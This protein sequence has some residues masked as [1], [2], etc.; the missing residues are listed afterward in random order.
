LRTA[1]LRSISRAA[2]SLGIAQPSLS[3]QLLRLEDEVGFQLFIRTARGVTV[4]EAGRI[5]QEHARHILRSI[6][7]A[8]EDVQAVNA[9]ASGQAVLALPYSI[10]RLLGVELVEAVINHAPSTSV[11]LVEAT[12]GQIRGWLDDG[13][14]DLGVLY[15]LGPI[16]HLSARRL[17]SEE[18]YLIGP[19]GRFGSSNEDA[20]DI[21]LS[22]LSHYPLITLGPQHGLRKFLDQ[23]AL[24]LGFTY[25]VSH[26]I[27]AVNTIAALVAKG[28]GC[29]VLAKPAV[30]EE[31]FSGKLSFARIGG[32]ALRRTL[33]LVRNPAQVITHASARVED[34]MI[35]SMASL[36]SKGAW[37]A[38][39][40]AA[41]R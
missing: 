23:E 27:D 21:P 12:T 30:D 1:D 31:L 41:L 4:T 38:E 7:Q 20:P 29:T 3:Q 15:D 36:I 35:K 25:R 6:D 24:R 28:H 2:E 11:R 22:E 33:S 17:A 10:N 9:A 5:F 39:P 18:M 34:L 13:R 37:E 26:E 40:E 16:R 14:I 32:G 19:A 8:L